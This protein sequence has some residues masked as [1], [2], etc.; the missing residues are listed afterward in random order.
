[1]SVS[2]SLINVF[3]DTHNVMRMIERLDLWSLIHVA[4]MM[5]IGLTQVQFINDEI[6]GTNIIFFFRFTW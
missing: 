1:M 6:F 3:Q 5:V 2:S 4:I